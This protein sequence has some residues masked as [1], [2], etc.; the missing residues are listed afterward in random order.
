MI[1]FVL[2]PVVVG[3]AWIFGSE[4][5]RARLYDNWFAPDVELVH[6]DNR[7]DRVQQR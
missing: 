1:E 5:K 2:I 6:L 4:I 3:L 7:G